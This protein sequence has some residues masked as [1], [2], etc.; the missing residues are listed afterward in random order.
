M[1]FLIIILGLAVDRF[2]GSLQELRRWDWMPAWARWL[3]GRFGGSGWWAGPWGL[4]ATLGSVLVLVGLVYQGLAATSVLL[5]FAFAL[6][7]LIYCLGPRSL[8]DD[9]EGLLEARARGDDEAAAMHAARIRGTVPHE[10][11]AADAEGSEVPGGDTG[12]NAAVDGVLVQAHER[13]FGVIFWFALLGPLGAVLYR[14]V[15]VMD[16]RVAAGDELGGIE[17]V[18]RRL[19]AILAWPVARLTALTYGLSG[20]MM[21]AM[22][23]LRPRL[24]HIGGEHER[25][26]TDV[27]RGALEMDER[28]DRAGSDEDDHWLRE[29]HGLVRRSLVVWLVILALLTLYGWVV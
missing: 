27:G 15:A 9:V 26:L 10:L 12:L 14:M 18:N 29:A 19:Y 24:T 22:A 20:S 1:T 28:H 3:A 11:G 16:R 8:D 5:G 6:L 17:A 7:V 21:D 4:L 2:L 25:L 23:Q 13:L